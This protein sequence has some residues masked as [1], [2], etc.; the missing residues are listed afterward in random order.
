MVLYGA[1]VQARSL[2]RCPLQ[3]ASACFPLIFDV[4]L[5]GALP[6]ETSAN[7]GHEIRG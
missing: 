6:I 2:V 7:A 5:A 1:P 4:T 3:I